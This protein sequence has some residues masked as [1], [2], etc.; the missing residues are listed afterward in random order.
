MDMINLDDLASQLG[1][2]IS[3]MVRHEVAMALNERNQNGSIQEG[4]A[5]PHV[6]LNQI[7]PVPIS[8]LSLSDILN[9]EPYASWTTPKD[10]LLSIIRRFRISRGRSMTLTDLHDLG[11]RLGRTQDRNLLLKSLVDSDL[12]ILS[13]VPSAK[14]GRLKILIEPAQTDDWPRQRP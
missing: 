2:L 4:S 14:N 1:R 13:Q 7:R 6:T 12:V 5:T 9:Q 3:E 11:R 10:R 8:K